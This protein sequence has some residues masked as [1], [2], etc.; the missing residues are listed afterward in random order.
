M[1]AIRGLISKLAF[2]TK[3]FESERGF[4]VVEVLVGSVVLVVGLIAIAQ[5]FSSAMAR[6]LDS[7]VRSV[8]HQ[9]ATKDMES[10]RGLPYDDVGLSSGGLPPVG[11]LEPIEYRDVGS[12]TVK[13]TRDVRF[14]ADDAYEGPFPQANYRR[15]TLSVEA[16][17][18]DGGVWTPRRG[19]RAVELVSNVAGGA[20]GAT[21]LVHVI[22]MMGDPVPEAKITIN[23]TH[24]IPNVKVD[25]STVKTNNMG[26]LLVPGLVPDDS[27]YYVVEASKVG[28]TSDS[29][30]D[31]ALIDST[32]QEIT[33]QI[34]KP[35]S[36]VIRLED[37]DGEPVKGGCF[38]V[39][40]PKGYSNSKDDLQE[41]E[42][43]IDGL[44][45]AESSDPYIVTLLEDTEGEY[46]GEAREVLLLPGTTEEV[47]FVVNAGEEPTTSTESTTTTTD[48]TTPPTEPTTTST[49]TT[50]TTLGAGSLQVTVYGYRPR[51]SGGG[52]GW[53]WGAISGASVSLGGTT[54]ATNSSGIVFFSNVEPGMYRLRVKANHQKDYSAWI[55][56]SGAMSVIVNM[57]RQY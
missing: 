48:P 45:F 49:T 26:L 56:V 32:L 16:G 53:T 9:V 34:D 33:L 25:H 10:I 43:R 47:V 39:T 40:G 46:P 15:V 12:L 27:G 1:N 4:S 18:L 51:G 2:R 22:D 20:G 55:Q 52:G 6:V 8:L 14:W 44:R 11:T 57:E 54:L 7:D 42:W 36:L 38:T 41:D 19:V 35:G 30:S 21:L 31:G 50:S 3:K 23:N 5:F 37:A 29:W 28:Y 13:I 24:L 17:Q